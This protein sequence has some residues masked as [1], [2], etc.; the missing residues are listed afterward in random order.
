MEK[1]T[2]TAFD[3]SE[4]EY[5]FNTTLGYTEPQSEGERRKQLSYPIGQIRKF[6]NET[7]TEDENGKA[8]QLALK[9]G[10]LMSRSTAGGAYTLAFGKIYSG[11][12]DP[13]ADLGEDGDIY[14]KY[15]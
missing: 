9:N 7:V 14:I 5:V 1:L 4:G 2:F 11:T 13:S 12:T 15:E 10:R 8:I 3:I 6:V